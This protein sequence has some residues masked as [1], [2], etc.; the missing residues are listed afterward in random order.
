M[1]GVPVAVSPNRLQALERTRQRLGPHFRE[2][3]V[4]G[5]RNAIGCVA[6]EITQ[7]CNLDCTLCY[8]SESSERVKDIPLAE[9]YRRIDGIFDQF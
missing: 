5:R 4:L 9:V 7:R 2:N 1:D 8:L 6:L 3:Q